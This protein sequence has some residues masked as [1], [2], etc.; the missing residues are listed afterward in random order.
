MQSSE[1][2][3][4]C[5][6]PRNWQSEATRSA[7]Q[8]RG[9][10]EYQ[11]PRADIWRN[12]EKLVARLLMPGVELGNVEVNVEDEVLSVLGKATAFES[13]NYQSVHKESRLGDYWRSFKLSD[14]IDVDKIEASMKDGLL[15]LTLPLSERI[16]PRKISIKTV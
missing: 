7:S 8:A 5:R 12:S 11:T 1:S 13:D 16:K 6:S 15:T 2:A 4:G 14:D 10:V 9:Y 3:G